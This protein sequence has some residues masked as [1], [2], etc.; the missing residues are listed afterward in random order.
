MHK[1]VANISL[2]QTTEVMTIENILLVCVYAAHALK[3][4]FLELNAISGGLPH[5]KLG[6]EIQDIENIP[7]TVP[8]YK[9]GLHSTN[10]VKM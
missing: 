2:A 6:R 9:Y 3:A 4:F 10:S 1:Y 5:F 7:L 8:K